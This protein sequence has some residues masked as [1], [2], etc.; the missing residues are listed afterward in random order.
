MKIGECVSR[1]NS[2]DLSQD[3]AEVEEI[4]VDRIS[5]VS[6]RTRPSGLLQP[7]QNFLSGERALASLSGRIDWSIEQVRDSC[8]DRVK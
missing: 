7:L 1:Q 2:L 6:S 3:C 5:T 8:V 4:E